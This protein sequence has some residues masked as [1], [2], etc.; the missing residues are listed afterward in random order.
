SQ[1]IFTFEGPTDSDEKVAKLIC[2][3]IIPSD[4]IESMYYSISK[5]STFKI[6]I[7]KPVS[8]TISDD[9]KEAIRK[10]STDSIPNF[11]KSSAENELKKIN[12]VWEVNN[13][14]EGLLDD[15]N[16]TVRFKP[17]QLKGH[18]SYKNE[19]TPSRVAK[20][21]LSQLGLLKPLEKNGSNYFPISVNK[22][23]RSTSG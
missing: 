5:G 23:R 13:V 9:G 2:D 3:K 21:L 16:H 6:F 11:I 1:I 19:E 18:I 14:I 15:V 22:I 10:I 20:I 12:I 4:H 17:N 7:K 8:T